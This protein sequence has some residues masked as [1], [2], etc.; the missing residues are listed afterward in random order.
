MSFFLLVFQLPELLPVLFRPTHMQASVTCSPVEVQNP[1]QALQTVNFSV[2]LIVSST[3]SLL[4]NFF[5]LIHPSNI[6]S[7]LPIYTK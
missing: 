3:E 4:R 6:E 5:R 2:V 7:H 1:N